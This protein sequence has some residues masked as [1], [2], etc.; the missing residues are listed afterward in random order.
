MDSFV[1]LIEII[2][3]AIIVGLIAYFIIHNFLNYEESRLKL[4]IDKS[5]QEI[6]F[7]ARMQAYERTILFLERST[8]ESLIRRVL[9]GNTTARFFQG[10]L[11]GTVRNEYEHNVTQQVYMSI[12][13]WTMVKTA[14]E[15]T[16]RL[17]NVSASKLQANASATDLAE[18]IL[19]IS[20][21]IGKL[22]IHVAI[23]NIKKE[24]S[25]YFLDYTVTGKGN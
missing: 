12:Q 19:T 23:E 10:E 13:A 20:S 18:H 4:E 17:I 3:P 11:I 16:I 9:K 14:T 6:I 7:P 15:E 2:M 21:Q 8:P 1:M 22:P 5:R 24:F 25:Q